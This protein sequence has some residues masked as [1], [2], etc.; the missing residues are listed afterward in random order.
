MLS[1]DHISG[2]TFII[3]MS[4][5]FGTDSSF[6]QYWIQT[7]HI[8][9]RFSNRGMRTTTGTRKTTRWYLYAEGVSLKILINK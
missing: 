7:Y 8:D 3:Y 4:Y 2:G 9:Q 6:F 1:A 5:S